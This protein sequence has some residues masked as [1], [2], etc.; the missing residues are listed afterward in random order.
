MQGDGCPRFERLD[1]LS[2]ALKVCS[3][4]AR[5]ICCKE[6]EHALAAHL[7]F[8]ED[9]ALLADFDCEQVDARWR[10]LGGDDAED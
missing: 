2:G 6:H 8:E 9:A 5:S 7:G 4:G 10:A 3:D 1:G